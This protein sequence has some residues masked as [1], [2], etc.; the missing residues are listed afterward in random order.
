MKVKFTV[1]YTKYD[2]FSVEL[3]EKYNEFLLY[4][5]GE[6]NPPTFFDI[7]AMDSVTAWEFLRFIESK[8]KEALGKECDSLGLFD[9]NWRMDW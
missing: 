2:T 6:E 5:E 9:D 1:P 4:E 8:A 7:D 3:P